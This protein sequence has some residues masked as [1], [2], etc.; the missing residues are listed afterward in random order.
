MEWSALG[1]FV[2]IGDMVAQKMEYEYRPVI[3]VAAKTTLPS[4]PQAKV[5]ATFP[6]DTIE[7]D[8]HSYFM[9]EEDYITLNEEYFCKIHHVNPPSIYDDNE[10]FQFD[11]TRLLSAGVTGL[12]FVSPVSMVWYPLLHRFMAKYLSHFLEGSFRYVVTKVLLENACLAAPLCLGYF[13][14]PAAVEGGDDWVPHLIARL[15]SDFAAT[16]ATDVSFWCVLST[17]NYKFVF[18]R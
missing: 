4:P 7:D 5:T 3:G 18:V 14:I 17:F 15:K 11:F 8:H 10:S 1:A 13:A 12:F 6:S 16:L 9:K 2:V